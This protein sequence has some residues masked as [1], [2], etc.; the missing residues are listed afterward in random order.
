M[1]RALGNVLVCLAL[2]FSSTLLAE[3]RWSWAL[4]QTLDD[5]SLSISFE[6]GS[7]WHTIHGAVHGARGEVRLSDPKNPR[8]LSVHALFPVKLFA[9]G[10][11]SRDTRMR[12]VMAEPR[13]PDVEV[14]ANGLPQECIP[15]TLELKGGCHGSL[16]GK[17]TI[18]GVTMEFPLPFSMERRGGLYVLEGKVTLDWSQF[19]VE[20]PSI[21]VARLAKQVTVHYLASVPALSQ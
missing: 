17:V 21:L 1:H 8:S 3:Q 10:N 6:V 9:T 12:E 13:F 15:E 2:L 5:Q 20:D 4:P 7:T 14:F 19:R 11:G 16:N 18:R